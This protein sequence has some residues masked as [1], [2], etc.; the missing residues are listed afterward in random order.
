MDK[1]AWY[2]QLV[3]MLVIFAWAMAMAWCYRRG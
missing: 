2:W 1:L 3:A